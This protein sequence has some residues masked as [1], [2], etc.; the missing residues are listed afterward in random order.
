MA[1]PKLAQEIPQVPFKTTFRD[2]LIKM[3]LTRVTVEETLKLIKDIKI[4]KTSALDNLSSFLFKEAMMVLPIHLCYIFNLSI[5]SGV[6]P[7]AWKC[8]NIILIPK[9]G[10]K[11]DPNNYRPISLLP[12]PGKLL[13]K[14]VH[15]RLYKYLT[16]NQILTTKQ[17]G[18]RPAHSTT[19]TATAFVTHILDQYN[20]GNHTAAIFVDLR[21]A[22]DSIDH[23]ILLSKLH[24]YGIRGHIHDW[25]TSYLSNRTQ[26]TFV[27]GTYSDPAIITYGVPQGSVLGPVLFL[28]FIND[29]TNLI[30][31]DSIFLYA[32]DTV[33][34]QSGNSV[35]E[36][37]NQ[38]QL[39]LD[40]FVD[41][42]RMNKLTLNTK[43][44]KSMNFLL[45]RKHPEDLNVEYI[46]NH[47]PLGIV[48]SYKYLGY[49]LDSN[50]NFG[51]LV[52][53]LIH[54]LNYKIY[55]LA[56]MRASLTQF[57]ALSV[58]K[59]TILSLMDYV[60]LFYSSFNKPMQRKLQVLQNRAI[61][62][63]LRLPNR[64]NVDE[65]HIRLNIWHIENR[66]WYFL[67]KFM[68][69]QTQIP[70]NPLIDRRPI[71]TRAHAGPAFRV[72]S[73][74]KMLYR[75][76]FIYTGMISW[77]NLQPEIRMIPLENQ[78]KS[79]LRS[80]IKVREQSILQ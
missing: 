70:G 56:R 68:F 25:F 43:K 27:N 21:K 79:Y 22:F 19:L 55:L 63:I 42:C 32:D 52:S 41:W 50:L 54:L 49:I 72:P 12:L 6:F 14:V 5:G 61:R 35:Q 65:Q 39:K 47:V 11:A 62:I 7:A 75:K 74:V 29:V 31:P 33:L 38:L 34:Y 59:S 69:A 73:Y 20:M 67:M 40:H 45:H 9:E 15:A 51:L 60:I 13:E 18:F 3:K 10:D 37:H 26:R 58:Y 44:T 24:A 53:K 28:L 2:F 1:G 71:M 76:S 17:G 66:H 57:A 46:V 4:S 36:V 77:N 80:E 30:D 48:D 64:T 16:D 8:S 78:F 23:Q